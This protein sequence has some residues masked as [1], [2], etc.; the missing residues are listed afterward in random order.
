MFENE[1]CLV[2]IKKST[3]YTFKFTEFIGGFPV[4][5]LKFQCFSDSDKVW[6]PVLWGPL[7]MHLQLH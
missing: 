4:I 1:C 5:L 2:N 6:G 3:F 7:G